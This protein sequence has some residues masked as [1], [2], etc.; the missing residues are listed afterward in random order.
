[1][2]QE[3][4]AEGCYSSHSHLQVDSQSSVSNYHKRKQALLCVEEPPWTEAYLGCAEPHVSHSCGWLSS[5]PKLNMEFQDKGMD[6]LKFSQSIGA[7]NW[8]YNSFPATQRGQREFAEFNQS[9][10]SVLYVLIWCCEVRGFQWLL[11]L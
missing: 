8:L 1:M 9:L 6:S 4:S 5:R 3:F 11:T 10:I 2:R 7:N